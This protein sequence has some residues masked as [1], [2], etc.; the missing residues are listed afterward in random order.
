MSWQ[1]LH[2]S[3]VD[4]WQTV[5]FTDISAHIVLIATVHCYVKLFYF[6]FELLPSVQQS[7]S[8][9]VETV[10]LSGGVGV[11]SSL[12]PPRGKEF[13]QCNHT[14]LTAVNQSQKPQS[15]FWATVEMWQIGF[16]RIRMATL[17]RQTFLIGPHQAGLLVLLSTG[18][19]GVAGNQVHVCPTVQ[20]ELH[21]ADVAV[22]AGAVQGWEGHRR[23]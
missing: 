20:Q 18:P 6:D 13:K 21:Q 10:S 17:T 19:A 4:R 2:M 7:S 22:E 12:T 9:W 15:R 14:F 16:K 11:Q 1:M 5:A 8:L 23:P 3:E